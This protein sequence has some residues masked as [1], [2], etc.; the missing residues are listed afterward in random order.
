MY[1]LINLSFGVASFSSGVKKNP[2]ISINDEMTCVRVSGNNTHMV[3]PMKSN[4]GNR[5]VTFKIQKNKNKMKNKM[6]MHPSMQPDCL[7]ITQ[8][9][10]KAGSSNLT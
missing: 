1:L 5:H 3:M 7:E 9:N 6:D 10:L 2:F 8:N 4:R